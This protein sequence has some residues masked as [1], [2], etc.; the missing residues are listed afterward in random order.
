MV[1]GDEIDQS[2]KCQFAVTRV[3]KL[4]RYQTV[5]GDLLLSMPT[6]VGAIAWKAATDRS[7]QFRFG[8]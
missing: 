7:V 8:Q 3:Y 6:S 1:L 5:A 4:G 2:I